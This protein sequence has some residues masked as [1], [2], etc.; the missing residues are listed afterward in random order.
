MKHNQQGSTL[1]EG[2][3]SL[4]IFSFGMLGTI[5]FQAN[6]LSQ[7]TQVSYRLEAS[8]LAD[9]LIGAAESDFAPDGTSNY[10]CYVYPQPNTVTANCAVANTY[11]ATWAERAKKM[12]GASTTAPTVSVNANNLEVNVYWKLPNEPESVAPHKF[13]SI[14]RPVGS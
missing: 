5:S 13:T 6:M 10:A 8:M 9:S 7:T 12:Q 3:I 4:L 14:T 2:M 1:L 11:M